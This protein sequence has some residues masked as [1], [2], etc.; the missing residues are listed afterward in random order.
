MNNLVEAANIHL[1]SNPTLS[2]ARTDVGSRDTLRAKAEELEGVF[3]N[4]LVSQM[5]SSIEARGAFGG[6]YAEETWRSMQAEQYA[7]MMAQ[8]GGIGLADQILAD[9]L[10]TQEALQSQTQTQ[11]NAQDAYKS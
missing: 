3:L 6:G 1:R 8:N 2:G 5:F 9:L 7:S 10:A 4:T 11:P